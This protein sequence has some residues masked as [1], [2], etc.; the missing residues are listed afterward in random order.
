MKAAEIIHI[1]V[2]ESVG[3]P[4]APNGD[5]Y[6]QIIL[7]LGLVGLGLVSMQW[8]NR[9]I[10]GSPSHLPS[11]ALPWAYFYAHLHAA[12]A[13]FKVGEE[14]ATKVAAL[15]NGGNGDSGQYAHNVRLFRTHGVAGRL[16][17]RAIMDLLRDVGWERQ[18]NLPPLAVTF[19]LSLCSS[20]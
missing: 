4:I 1:E 6:P 15:L 16:V 8:C 11:C 12:E 10:G 3:F 18:Q 5:T 2:F 20:L 9:R 13:P 7:V 17:V 14:L 19:S